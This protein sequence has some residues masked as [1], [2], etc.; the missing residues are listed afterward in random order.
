MRRGEVLFDR[1]GHRKY[2][3]VPERKAFFD[4]VCAYMEAPPKAF[5]LMLYY[6]GCRISEALELTI[7]QIDFS[8]QAVVFRTLKRRGDHFRIV[9]IPS[10]LVLL[11]QEVIEGREESTTRLWPFCRNTGHRMVKHCMNMASLTGIKACPKGLRHAFAVACITNGVP[12]T[13]LQ[14]WMGHARLETT[15][16][17][18]DMIGE[19]DR[20]Q[21]EKI[22]N[23]T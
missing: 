12:V 3:N 15:S 8:E 10:S 5:C 13:T 19:E 18:L 22:W 11:L 16:I 1:N 23:E 14:R 21:A 7:E 6:T 20:K 17:Y 4:A 2:L 9:P